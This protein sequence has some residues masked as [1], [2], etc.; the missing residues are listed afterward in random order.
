MSPNRATP[1]VEIARRSLGYD[2]GADRTHQ[3]E[4]G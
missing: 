2:G 1:G 3:D 4:S